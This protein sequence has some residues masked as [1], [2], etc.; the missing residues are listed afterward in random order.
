MLDLQGG[1][2]LSSAENAAHGCGSHMLGAG[3][4][5]RAALPKNRTTRTVGGCGSQR[6]RDPDSA[7]LQ[8]P[9]WARFKPAPDTTLFA[10]LPWRLPPSLPA[11]RGDMPSPGFP[12]QRGDPRS[13]PSLGE[14]HPIVPASRMVCP[15]PGSALPSRP[16]A[17][18]E[19]RGLQATCVPGQFGPLTPPPAVQLSSQTHKTTDSP[20]PASI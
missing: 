9:E 13:W 20:G 19:P 17:G 18:A 8:Q 14:P 1:F 7:P 3:G 15:F 2:L 6:A 10:W 12:G 5:H 4:E 11:G 16:P